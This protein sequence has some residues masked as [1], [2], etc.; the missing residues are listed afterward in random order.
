MA[1]MMDQQAVDPR[2]MSCRPSSASASTWVPADRRS[3]SSSLDGDV[4]DYE[5][6]RG[7]DHLRSRRRRHARSATSGGT[8]IAVATL[9]LMATPGVTKDRV[10]A[11]AVTGQYASTV[12][13]DANGGQ[14]DRA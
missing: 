5:L 4:L 12:P 6:H 10:K 13:V 14:P 2:S 3:G 8:L 11:V 7:V 9:R 1:D